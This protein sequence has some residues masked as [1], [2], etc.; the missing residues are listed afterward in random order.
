MFA[1][2]E[3]LSVSFPVIRPPSALLSPDGHRL[4]IER[5]REVVD[6]VD[7]D[8]GNSLGA[9]AA[10]AA[11]SFAG[12]SLGKPNLAFSPDGPPCFK[13]QKTASASG[14]LPHP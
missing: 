14:K 9:F 5:S 12:W 11:G 6:L 3:H 13:A 4:A 2:K 8:T 10:T 7:A 1:W